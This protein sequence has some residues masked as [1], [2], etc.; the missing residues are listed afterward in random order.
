[1]ATKKNKYKDFFSLALSYL[2]NIDQ[3]ITALR[4][5]QESKKFDE[6]LAVDMI[7][8][9]AQMHANGY[10]GI[11]SISEGLLEEKILEEIAKDPKSY[12]EYLNI[13]GKF[14]TDFKKKCIIVT[15]LHNIEQM[16]FLIG[17]DF[18]NPEEKEG[19]KEFVL[20]RINLFKKKMFTDLK[21][22]YPSIGS[23]GSCSHN[24]KHVDSVYSKIETAFKMAKIIYSDDVHLFRKI[25]DSLTDFLNMQE[26][27]LKKIVNKNYYKYMKE[28]RSTLEQFRLENLI[29]ETKKIVHEL[30]GDEANKIISKL[31]KESLK[32]EATNLNKK[33]TNELPG[34]AKKLSEEIKEKYESLSLDMDF[35]LK[36]DLEKRLDDTNKIITKYLS[37]AP[38]YRDVLK[39]VEG[40]SAYDMMI[41][42]LKIVNQDFDK[43]IQ[44]HNQGIV[45]DMSVLN[46]KNIAKRIL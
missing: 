3:N 2:G 45:N 9:C 39:N 31:K 35:A 16:I 30:S 33:L 27:F 7:K 17:D 32:L 13:Y 21:I 38:D 40:K 42:S 1:M 14:S 44:D 25:N 37:I 20:E 11:S 12:N 4:H 36:I 19:W 15:K 6:F 26:K 18:N 34:D 5:M 46:R 24:R 29:Q 8:Q 22:E 41:E 23:I 28:N 10:P 43:L